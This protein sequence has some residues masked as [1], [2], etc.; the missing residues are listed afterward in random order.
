MNV[1]QSLQMV[2]LSKVFNVA[3]NEELAM[4]MASKPSR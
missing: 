2:G 1:K 4:K 3:P